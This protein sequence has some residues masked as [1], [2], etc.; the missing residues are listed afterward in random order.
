MSGVTIRRARPD[1][2][3]FLLEL[4][5]DDDVRPFLSPKSAL[6]REALLEEIAQSEREPEAFGRFVIDV[7]GERAGS[8]AFHRSNERSGIAWLSRLAVAPRFRG[9]R[10]ADDAARLLQRMLFEELGYHR[11]EMEIYGFNE[12]AQAHAERVGWVREGVKRRAYRYG[13]DWVDSVMY[14]LL[15][16]DLGG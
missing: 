14:A 1:D 9:R 8:M 4:A 15:E 6:G 10:V 11:L 5:N 16:D 13:D 2:A 3:D 7:D 12:R